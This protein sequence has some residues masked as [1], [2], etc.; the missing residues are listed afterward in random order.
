MREYNLTVTVKSD[1]KLAMRDILR[2]VANQIYSDE[3]SPDQVGAMSGELRF[4]DGDMVD[5]NTIVTYTSEISRND[6]LWSKW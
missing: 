5:W 6:R 3:L 1:N 4:E 2:E